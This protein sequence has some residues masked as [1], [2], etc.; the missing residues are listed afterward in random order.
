MAK[1]K[2][3]N[4][5]ILQS[6]IRLASVRSKN[7]SARSYVIRVIFGSEDIFGAYYFF[8]HATCKVHRPAIIPSI[9]MTIALED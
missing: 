8:L 6:T 3:G 7:L 5:K 2:L 9:A 4:G 1:L